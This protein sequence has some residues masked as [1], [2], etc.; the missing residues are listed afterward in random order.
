M[1]LGRCDAFGGT[2]PADEPPL[3]DDD[4]FGLAA[5]GAFLIVAV[6]F[7]L[8]RPSTKRLLI[9][10]PVGVAAGLLFGLIARSWVP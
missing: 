5:F 7:F 10:L 4:V 2:C 9:A 6:P 8:H 3:F 1:T